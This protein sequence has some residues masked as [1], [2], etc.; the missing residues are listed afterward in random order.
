L[1]F[2][3]IQD[4]DNIYKA[5]L[6]GVARIAQSGYLSDFNNEI[7]CPMF[8]PE[9]SDKFGFTEDEVKVLLRHHVKTEE[10]DNVKKWYNGYKAAMVYV[11]TTFGQL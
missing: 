4:N 6:V 11:F 10:A 3:L 2:A 9:M 8:K 5:L 1:L 7:V